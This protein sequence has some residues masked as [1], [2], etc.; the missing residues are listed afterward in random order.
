M[1][2]LLNTLSVIATVIVASGLVFFIL[3]IILGRI[4]VL[5]IFIYQKAGF[6][7]KHLVFY[8]L[9]AFLLLRFTTFYLPW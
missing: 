7:I 9:A 4:A 3:N 1:T 2:Y 5:N 8:G 6:K